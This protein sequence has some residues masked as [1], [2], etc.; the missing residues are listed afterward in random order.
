MYVTGAVFKLLSGESYNM[1]MERIETHFNHYVTVV[2]SWPHDEQFEDS[3][4]K[5][6]LCFV[7]TLSSGVALTRVLF[8]CASLVQSLISAKGCLV[9]SQQHLAISLANSVDKQRKLLIPMMSIEELDHVVEELENIAK[10]GPLKCCQGCLCL[11]R[12]IGDR[13]VGEF[14]I[15]VPHVKQVKLS[16]ACGRLVIS[17]DGVWDALS[18]ESALECSRGLAPELAAAQIFKARKQKNVKFV[19]KYYAMDSIFCI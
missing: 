6:K 17:S 10:I 11:S 9:L 5:V 16:S 14:I 12:S 2:S 1:I 7:A 4:R 15:P 13:E 3:L 19:I 8:R 18:T